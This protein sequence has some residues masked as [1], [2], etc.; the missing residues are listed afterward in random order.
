MQP[1]TTTTHS[2]KL[3]A[4]G[5]IMKLMM[6]VDKFNKPFADDV[7]RTAAAA[8]EGADVI[9]TGALT[10]TAS[11]CIAEKLGVPWV[12]R[13]AGRLKGARVRAC[14]RAQ[15][16]GI[17]NVETAAPAAD[18]STQAARLCIH[19]CFHAPRCPRAP[20]PRAGARVPRPRV[21]D[22][23][24]L[25]LGAQ[26]QAVALEVGQQGLLHVSSR[27]ELRLRVHAAQGSC[28]ARRGMLRA[29]C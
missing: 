24:V 2:Q 9:V 28:L 23:R 17:C 18:A 4:E 21:A 20:W 15:R 26:P 6:E 5:K 13:V 8:G 12:R 7:L 25:L 1:N 19:R 14:G 3:L 27:R 22:A 29:R 16:Q 11:M 10:Q